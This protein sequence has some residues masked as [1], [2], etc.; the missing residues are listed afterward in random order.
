MDELAEGDDSHTPVYHIKTKDG[1]SEKVKIFL[2]MLDKQ[3]QRNATGKRRSRQPS[4][5]K[6]AQVLMATAR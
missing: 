6:L 4:T 3:R 2:R 5:G 1:H